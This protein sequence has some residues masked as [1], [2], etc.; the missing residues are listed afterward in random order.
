MADSLGF[1]LAIV[2][3]EIVPAAILLYGAYWAFA[4]RRALASP[5][6]RNHALWLGGVGVLIAIAVFLTYSDDPT[7]SAAMNIFYS[8]LFAVIFAFIDST[9]RVARRSD[10]LLRSILQ[11]EKLRIV[12]WID[13]VLL[14]FV[15]IYSIFNLSFGTGVAANILGNF[16]IALPF[17]A[18][19]P[20]MLIGARRSRDAQL[21]VSMK[22]LGMTLVLAIG[23]ALVNVIEGSFLGISQ[24]DLYYSYLALPAGAIWIVMAYF[25]YKSARSL[26]SVNP[27]PLEVV[28]K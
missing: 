9:V 5:I 2:F 16:F 25:F 23:P 1:A 28:A 12:I 3:A 11:W 6:Y 21:R 26:A 7:V 19:G 20:A 17:L 13:I 10:P 22:W 8:V 24:F 15:N 18:G 14:A 4:I 27:M